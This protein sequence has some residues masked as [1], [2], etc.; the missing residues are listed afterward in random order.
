MDH[1]S[2]PTRRVRTP[3]LST[4]L[5]P[6]KFDTYRP[7]SCTVGF[8]PHERYDLSALS[9]AEWS[10]ASEPARLRHCGGVLHSRSAWLMVACG[11]AARQNSSAAG[12]AAGSSGLPPSTASC[13]RWPA[14]SR[15]CAH[16][17]LYNSRFLTTVTAGVR[18][19]CSA[20]T[21]GATTSDARLPLMLQAVRPRRIVKGQECEAGAVASSRAAPTRR[22]P[23]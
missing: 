6:V 22:K 7:N 21:R 16:A 13:P 19:S 14:H 4:V 15:S 12:I 9:R 2:P 20:A 18:R 8:L 17:A 3:I 23:R 10:R 1:H 5:A 11:L